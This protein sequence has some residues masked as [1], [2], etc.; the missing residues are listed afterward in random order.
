MTHYS[1]ILLTFSILYL[2]TAQCFILQYTMFFKQMFSLK[3]V[4]CF[5]II[6]NSDNV[7]FLCNSVYNHAHFLFSLLRG[8]SVICASSA[9]H[10]YGLHEKVLTF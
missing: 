7:Y 9:V 2:V 4:I 3:N 10:R 8:T 1:F 6:G 5:F